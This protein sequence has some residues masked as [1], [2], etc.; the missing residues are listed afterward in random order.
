MIDGAVNV[1]AGE[2]GV[3]EELLLDEVVTDT[4]LFGANEVDG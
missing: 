4:E 2:V 3:C 1:L